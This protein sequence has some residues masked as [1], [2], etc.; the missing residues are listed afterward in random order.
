MLFYKIKN[1]KIEEGY[2]NVNQFYFFVILKQ[3]IVKK[4]RI[5]M[6]EGLRM[7]F[8]WDV[9]TKV[10]YDRKNFKI[11]IDFDSLV[12]RGRDESLERERD[13]EG[14]KEQQRGIREGI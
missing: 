10:I 5:I 14:E 4:V 7:I 12:Q 6:K 1:S 9:D 11:Y 13:G 8:Y 3:L 2:I